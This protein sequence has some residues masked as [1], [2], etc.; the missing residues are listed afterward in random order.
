MGP[1]ATRPAPRRLRGAPAGGGRGGK[2]RQPPGPVR[3]RFA[4]AASA[5]T[6]SGSG[7]PGPPGEARTPRRGR[8][9]QGA[10]GPS[11]RCPC[12]KNRASTRAVELRQEALLAGSDL[13]SSPLGAF[14]GLGLGV[15]TGLDI[16]NKQASEAALPVSF[17]R[18]PS[19]SLAGEGLMESKLCS[20]RTVCYIR[21]MKA[22]FVSGKNEEMGKASW[23]KQAR[24]AVYS[25]RL[26]GQR[27]VLFTSPGEMKSG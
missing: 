13:L 16:E 1:P 3:A 5:R 24:R 21:V 17:L 8:A 25:H 6:A 23:V 15:G 27:N 22:G 18:T 11:L 2:P 9:P 14:A 20:D 12:A 10:L 4:P 26:S 19:S 7:L